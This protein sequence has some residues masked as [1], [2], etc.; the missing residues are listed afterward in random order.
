[1]SFVK[2]L[3]NVSM[4]ENK[5][6]ALLSLL[7]FLS[8]GLAG[9]FGIMTETNNL[10]ITII[11]EKPLPKPYFPVFFV[12]GLIIPVIFLLFARNRSHLKIVIYPYLILLAGQILTEISLVFLLGKGIGVLIGLVFSTAR[13]IQI[14]QLLFLAERSKLMK[15]FL[16]MQF[17]LWIFNVVQISLNRVYPLFYR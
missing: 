4:K 6:V 15:L 16:Y 10:L 1:M 7:L 12:V 17:L 9:I 8:F 3:F 2:C 14:K 13:L 5:S 11:D